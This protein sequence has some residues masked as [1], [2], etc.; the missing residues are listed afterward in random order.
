VEEQKTLPKSSVFQ[1]VQGKGQYCFETARSKELILG[2]GRRER[3][4]REEEGGGEL[5]VWMSAKLFARGH[6]HTIRAFCLLYV[7]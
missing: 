6:L 3:E 7:T 5:S 1:G 4:S 2:T